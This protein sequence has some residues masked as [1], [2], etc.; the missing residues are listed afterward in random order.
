[1]ATERISRSFFLASGVFALLCA[2]LI[3]IAE[4]FSL[5]Q[6]PLHASQFIAVLICLPASLIH[7]GRTRGERAPARWI[8]VAA[9]L[10]ATAW[11]GFIAYVVGTL[12]F[13]AD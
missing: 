4:R 10:L 11:L 2:P 3:V 9:A 13:G 6:W 12:D 5:P 1:M 7:L 8:A